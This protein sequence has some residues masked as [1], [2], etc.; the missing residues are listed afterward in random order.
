VTRIIGLSFPHKPAMC[1]AVAGMQD[2]A[3]A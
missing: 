1:F 2:V 3:S